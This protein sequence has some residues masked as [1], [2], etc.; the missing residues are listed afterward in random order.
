MPR[1]R[2]SASLLPRRA[3]D[4]LARR[5]QGRDLLLLGG[6]KIVEVF[7]G[8]SGLSSCRL[9]A[10]GACGA[11]RPRAPSLRRSKVL[12]TTVM[13]GLVRALAVRRRPA[14]DQGGRR[15]EFEPAADVL[16]LQAVTMIAGFAVAALGYALLSLREHAAL[17]KASLVALV[18]RSC[19]RCALRTRRDR[20][21]DRHR[22]RGGDA[23]ARLR[24]VSRGRGARAAAEPAD[25]DPR[26]RGDRAGGRGRLAAARADARRLTLSS[27]VYFGVLALSGASRGSWTPSSSACV[28]VR[29]GEAA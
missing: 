3:D 13:V 29:G 26:L 12:Q 6:F 21:G 10:A 5:D 20:R 14:R 28:S 24:V 15:R 8:F 19:C 17:V 7:G 25:L 11:R 22:G 16:R 4:P 9:P 2:P 27:A 18:V 1:R 23:D